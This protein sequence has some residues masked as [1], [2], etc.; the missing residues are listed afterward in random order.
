MN[1]ESGSNDGRVGKE[2]AIRI[3]FHRFVAAYFPAFCGCRVLINFETLLTKDP[4]ETENKM[5]IF[6]IQ[7][8][9][10]YSHLAPT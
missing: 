6:F 2:P 4:R 5:P 8:K 1:L 3:D 10:F 7:R 9:S